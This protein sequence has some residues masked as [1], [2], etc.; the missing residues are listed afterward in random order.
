[1]YHPSRGGVR[2][3]QDQFDWEDVKADKYRENYL[4]ESQVCS[5]SLIT[6]FGLLN[7]RITGHL[8]NIFK[9]CSHC[10]A[11]VKN[12][13]ANA[14]MTSNCIFIILSSFTSN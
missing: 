4:G 12:Y 11:I 5:N 1:M 7:F 13:I 9:S 14:K 10:P 6:E 8:I 3:G 2:G